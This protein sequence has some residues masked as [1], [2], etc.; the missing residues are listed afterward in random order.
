M[1]YLIYRD[2]L[3]PMDEWVDKVRAARN[4]YAQAHN[5]PLRKDQFDW[6]YLKPV[7]EAPAAEIELE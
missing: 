4:Q 6:K 7:Y 2:L 3:L 5:I 1:T